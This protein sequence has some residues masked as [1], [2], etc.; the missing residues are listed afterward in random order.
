AGGRA[1]AVGGVGRTGGGAAASDERDD[2][3]GGPAGTW[4]AVARATGVRAQPRTPPDADPGNPGTSGTPAGGAQPVPVTPLRRPAGGSAGGAAGRSGLRRR[5]PVAAA[6]LVGLAVGGALGGLLGARSPQGGPD[7]GTAPVVVAAARLDP[8]QGSGS[9][10]AEVESVGERRLVHLHVQGVAPAEDGY[11]EAWLLD[12]DGGL[13]ALGAVD[14]VD[15]AADLTVA[16]PASVDVGRWSTVDVS[17]EA[18]DG[19]PA[20]GGDSVLR[21]TLAPRT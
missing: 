9:G 10:S 8:L 11:L 4:A 15:G 13:V 16:L 17:R 3:A 5:L 6:L 2:P 1:R 14:P 7:P 12:A 19:D 18:A 21:G 20:H